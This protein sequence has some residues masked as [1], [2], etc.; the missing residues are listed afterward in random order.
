MIEACMN[1][2]EKYPKLK[3]KRKIEDQCWEIYWKRG[4]KCHGA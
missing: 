3:H 1:E 2:I 4:F